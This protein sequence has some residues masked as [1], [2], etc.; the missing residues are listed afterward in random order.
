M[1]GNRFFSPDKVQEIDFDYVV[2]MA[3]YYD[4]IKLQLIN[5][6]VAHDKILKFEDYCLVDIVE[7][8]ECEKHYDRFPVAAEKD[9]L[10]GRKTCQS[11][12]ELWQYYD[13]LKMILTETNKKEPWRINEYE[14]KLRV[15]LKKQVM[16]IDKEKLWSR[17][18]Y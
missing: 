5:L 6:G 14:K 15:L 2:I 11:G 16:L 12:E 10:L 4:E 3:T 8:V 1:K 13:F 17:K 18:V 7:K 9:I